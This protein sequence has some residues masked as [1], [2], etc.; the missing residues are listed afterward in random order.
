PQDT[1]TLDFGPIPPGAGGRGAGGGGRGGGRGGSGNAPFASTGQWQ[2]GIG[3]C[4]SG[5]TLADHTDPDIIWATCYGNK[6]TRFDNKLGEARSVA[7]WRMTLDA[8]PTELKYRCH[9][10]P[11]LALDPFDANTAYYGCQVVF[12][13]TN[14]GQS[15]AVISPDLSTGNPDRI[16]NSG[17]I[18][19]DNLGQFYGA[20][21]FAI[22]PSALKRGLIWA[23]TNDGKI[24]VTQNGGTSWSDVTKNVGMK[25]DATVRQ[26]AP[27]P[28]DPGTAYFTAD[29]HLLDDRAPYIYKTTDYGKTWKLV[30]GNLP[31]DHPLDYAMSVAVNPNK[32]GML[33]AGTGHAFYYSTDDGATWTHFRTGLPAA[34]VTWIDVPKPWHD[35][36][37]STYG[38][39]IYVLRDIAPLEEKAAADAATDDFYVY[40]PRVGYREARA[41]RAD[42]QFD[43]K[44]V[45]DGLITVEVLDSAGTT[46]RTM[47]GRGRPGL[48]KVAWNLRYDPPV[49]VEMRHT[50]PEQPFIWDDPRFAGRDTRPVIHWGIQSPQTTGPI[51]VPGRYGVRVTVAGKSQVRRFVVLRNDKLKTPIADLVASTRAQ[52]RIR[53]NINA[54]AEM[55]NRI[56]VMRRQVQDIAKA[57]TTKADAKAALAALEQKIKDVELTMLS[58]SDMMSDD[59]YYPEQ[60]RIY[61]NLLWLQGEVGTGASDVAGGAEYR[62]TNAS[63]QTLT[64]LDKDLKDAK[65]KFDDLMAKV[66]PDFNRQWAGK[67]APISDKKTAM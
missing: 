14:A 53:D 34:P 38:R 67:L 47:K 54:T 6:V 66:I 32:A 56:E 42:F 10:T 5:F 4:E 51:A 1:T 65:K 52:I 17:G 61:L 28:F 12:K 24:W 22:A 23:G 40:T 16:V 44:K 36:V 7:P 27:S 35:V 46:I 64:E 19:K 25:P 60:Y 9:W 37:V 59:K 11:P 55:V 45:P 30:S 18:V 58:N 13:T 57:D 33:F 3:G 48:N 62:P 26:I 63:L 50:P 43:L 8:P 20:V 49:Q 31:K 29:R 15:W 41:G 2:H 21:V 39:G